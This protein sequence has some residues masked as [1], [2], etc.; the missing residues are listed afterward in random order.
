MFPTLIYLFS[1]VFGAF[2]AFVGFGNKQAI[3][4]DVNTRVSSVVICSHRVHYVGD[5]ILEDHEHD[6][7]KYLASSSIY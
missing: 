7:S 2:H 3:F 1:V 5:C 4:G 6:V